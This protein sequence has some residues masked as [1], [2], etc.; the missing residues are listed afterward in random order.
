M[1]GREAGDRQAARESDAV[2]RGDRDAGQGR[3]GRDQ[4]LS[5]L[6]CAQLFPERDRGP[7]RSIQAA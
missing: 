7:L 3:A 1:A 5:R 6:L 4:A 2:S